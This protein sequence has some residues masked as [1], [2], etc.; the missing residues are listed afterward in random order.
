MIEAAIEKRG[1]YRFNKN[2]TS[3]RI[4]NGK[5]RKGITMKTI[6]CILTGMIY[7]YELYLDR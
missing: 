3:E 1:Y 7:K 2:K 4:C 5:Y 6:Q